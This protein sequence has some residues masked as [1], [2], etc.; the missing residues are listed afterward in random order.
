[1][2]REA[3]YSVVIG[4]LTEVKKWDGADHPPYRA[5]LAPRAAIAGPFD[6][7]L[8]PTIPV[9]FDVSWTSS[10][11]H[12]PPP[13]GATVM[14]VLQFMPK[15]GGNPVDSAFIVSDECEFMPGETA[16]VVIKGLD[17]PRV[18]ETLK[19]IQ[20]ARLHQKPSTTRPAA[21]TTKN[22][23]STPPPR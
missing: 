1:M 3:M 7:S 20:A 13:N 17:D 12:E 18:A 10:S 4:T 14:V 6:P 2:W 15:G 5:T 21:P 22:A 11:I 9:S 23:T 16:L 8:Y 19:K